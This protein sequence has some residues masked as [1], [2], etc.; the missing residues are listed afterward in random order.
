MHFQID[1]E[2]CIGCGL[3]ARKCPVDC[4]F[5]SREDKYEI[6]QIDCVKCGSCFEVCPVNAISKLPGMHEDVQNHTKEAKE[7]IYA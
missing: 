3:C 5:G 6:T 4:I 1:K 7:N 2:K